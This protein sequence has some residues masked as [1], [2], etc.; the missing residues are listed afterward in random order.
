[1]KNTKDWCKARQRFHIH[2]RNMLMVEDFLLVE[3]HWGIEICLTGSP[4][5]PLPNASRVIW[6]VIFEEDVLTKEIISLELLLAWEWILWLRQRSVSEL[7]HDLRNL[8]RRFFKLRNL[9]FLLSGSLRRW[10]FSSSS[11]FSASGWNF[12]MDRCIGMSFFR[13][14][15]YS[16]CGGLRNLL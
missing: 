9:W 3:Q 8:N 6:V 5:T 10:L 1:M 13:A 11:F 7:H 4:K 2:V 14:Y 15:V 12:L 16:L